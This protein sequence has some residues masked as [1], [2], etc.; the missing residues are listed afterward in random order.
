MTSQ[1]CTITNTKKFRIGTVEIPSK[2]PQVPDVSPELFSVFYMKNL[3]AARSDFYRNKIQNVV[4]KS[5]IRKLFLI[6]VVVL[7]Q[8][9][10][11]KPY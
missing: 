1:T 3:L 6:I 7:V 9:Y 4:K 2:A 11:V 5:D 8:A 10:F